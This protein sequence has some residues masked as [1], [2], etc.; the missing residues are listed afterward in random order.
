MYEEYVKERKKFIYNTV[1]IEDDDVIEYGYH[2]L[3]EI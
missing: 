1:K 3:Q 2:V